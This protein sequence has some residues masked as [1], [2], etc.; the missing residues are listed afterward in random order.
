[1]DQLKKFD[2]LSVFGY[3]IHHSLSRSGIRRK[4]II[5]LYDNSKVI[6]FDIYKTTINHISK[7]INASYQNVKAAIV[8]DGKGYKRDESLIGLGLVA[9][10]K[11]GSSIVYFLT[12]KGREVAK[13]LKE[14]L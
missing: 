9:F 8:G 1:M 4:S 5:L 11:V 6:D 13:L 7:S 12:E 3:K 10:E 2:R 14:L